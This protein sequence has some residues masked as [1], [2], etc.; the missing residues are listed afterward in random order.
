MRLTEEELID[1]WKYF[2]YCCLP[3]IT[4][5]RY[6]Y[7]DYIND[8]KKEK[9]FYRHETKQAINKIGK[10]LEV[11]PN[12]LMDVSN[13]NIRYM[14]ILGD[15]IDEQF[16]NEKE[17]LHKAI[18]LSFRNA[19]WEHLDCLTALHF[20]FTML[21]IAAVTYTQCCKDLKDIKGK[22]FTD[23]FHVYD[24]HELCYDWNKVISK[25]NT[26]LDTVKKSESV[27]LQNLRCNKAI[28]AIR[29]KLANIE[30]LRIAMEKSYPWSP[31]YKE[32]IPY[33]DSADYLI[34]NNN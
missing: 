30:T 33:E 24:L 12:R 32:E 19:K 18:F 4:M 3:S 5:A 26:S 9:M 25:A 8:I 28:N 16:E 29:K 13:Q 27:D 10:Y 7:L 6:A 23:V 22:D 1:T 15:N 31:N 34:V 2:Q 14:N 20:I 21:Q 17:E 11:L